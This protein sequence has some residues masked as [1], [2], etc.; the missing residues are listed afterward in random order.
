MIAL[1]A[2]LA[3]ALIVLWARRTPRALAWLLCAV[4]GVA[5]AAACLAVLLGALH[6]APSAPSLASRH[7]TSRASAPAA[8]A[9]ALGRAVA[10]RPAGD[11]ARD[12]ISANASQLHAD[13][14]RDPA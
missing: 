11:P 6:S 5:G 9:P 1:A 10:T 2:F 12:R 13:A 4:L 3:C 7:P 8:H 14:A